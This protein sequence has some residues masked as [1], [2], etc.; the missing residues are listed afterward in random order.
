MDGMDGYSILSYAHRVGEP[1]VLATLVHA[2]G[3][4]YRK[5]G[6]AMLLLP[7][8][9]KV[10][11]LSPGCLES[12]LQERTQELLQSGE[13]EL[14]AYNMRPEEDAIWGEAI[15]C[16][17]VIRILLEPMGDQCLNSL[18]EAYHSVSAGAEV[19]MI[20]YSAG[21]K[22]RY[23]F[24]KISQRQSA[25]SLTKSGQKPLF[26]TIFKP[27]TRLFVY[28]TD[29]GTVPIARAASR[30]GFRVAIGDWRS[31]LCHSGRFPGAELAVGSPEAIVS[32]LNIRS[33]DYVL[34]CSHQ[35]RKDR[36]MLE[37]LLPLKP[38]YLGIMG[39]KNRIKHL[40][41]GLPAEGVVS[42]PVGLDIGAEGPEEI[43]VSIAAELIAVRN[44]RRRERE[45]SGIAYRWDLYGGGT[46]QE[47]EG[48]QAF[49]GA[50]AR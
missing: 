46:E 15:G 28:G 11:S 18:A 50:C 17:G 48:S 43:A 6:A 36:E 32:S 3:H 44:S 22:L 29:E 40:T 9:G 24:K 20:R 16:G 21:R 4:S 12:D 1:A 41:N 23:E 49:L 10:G 14:V 8:G 13:A 39:S 26:S 2:E 25:A 45:V 7:D 47:N 35:M 34:I 38:A 5:A 37:L 31:T 42:A 30:I 27:R 19:E 33:S